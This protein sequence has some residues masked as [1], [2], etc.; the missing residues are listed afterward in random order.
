MKTT[1]PKLVIFILIVLFGWWIYTREVSVPEVSP[2]APIESPSAM[3]SFGSDA[4]TYFVE[5]ADTDMLRER[6]LSGRAGLYDDEGMLFVFE[7]LDMHGFWMKD[8]NF[9]IHIIWMDQNLEVVDV[10]MDV[11]PNSYPATFMPSKPS[12]YALEVA[13]NANRPYGI[14]SVGDLATITYAGVAP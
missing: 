2:I 7:S 9:P 13:A 4:L 1:A 14:P 8:M 12:Q 11:Q 10:L 6:G 3:V 5:V